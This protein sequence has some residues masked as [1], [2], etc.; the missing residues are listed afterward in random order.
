MAPQL[1]LLPRVSKVRNAALQA[2]DSRVECGRGGLV[3]APA[4]L[5]HGQCD[6]VVFCS[7]LCQ[8]PRA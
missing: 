4:F 1:P 6:P 3:G 5:H 2:P 8:G 7:C